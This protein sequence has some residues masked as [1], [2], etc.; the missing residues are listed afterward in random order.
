[1]GRGDGARGV[2]G[3]CP[4][5]RSFVVSDEGGYGVAFEEFSAVEEAQFDEECDARD[6]AAGVLDE[7]AH[8]A[9]GAAGGEEVVYDE[10]AVTAGDGVGVDFEG[11]WCR[12]P[13]S[14]EAEII[15]RGACPACEQDE[16]LAGAV[17]E[18]GAEDEAAG[19]G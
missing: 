3:V 11:V 16:P 15:S 8:G 13:S 12:I 4:G 7:L 19:F 14:Y 10:D 9:G 5:P 18:G 17:C 6:G 2:G 1:M